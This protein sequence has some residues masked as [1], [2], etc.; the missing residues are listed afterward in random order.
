MPPP[1]FFRFIRRRLHLYHD[2]DHGDDDGP[3]LYRRPTGE[4]MGK[5]L[6]P[7]VASPLMVVGFGIIGGRERGRGW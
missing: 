1:D 2:I 4:G 5:V 7:V 6:V 3:K